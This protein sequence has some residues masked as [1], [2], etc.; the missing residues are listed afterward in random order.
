MKRC[1]VLCLGMSYP[2]IHAQ[3]ETEG[4]RHDV[5]ETTQTSI[6][7]VVECVR[8]RILTEMDG[9]DLARCIAME[10]KHCI[11]AFTASQENGSVYV[12]GKHFSGNFNRSGFVDSIK[13]Q[14]GEDT[15]F[16]QIILDYFWC[17]KGWVKEHWTKRFFHKVIP[18]L[19]QVL[20]FP[21]QPEGKMGHGV[22]YLPFCFHIMKELV[23]NLGILQD[24]YQIG[25]VYKS[26]LAEN[27]LWSGTNS[28][29]PEIMQDYLGK[30]IQQEE[31]YCTFGPQD[32]YEEMEDARVT[33]SEVIDVLRRIEDFPLVRMIRLRPLAKHCTQKRCNPEQ[34]ATGGFV[35]LERPSKIV[36]GFDQMVGAKAGENDTLSTVAETDSLD[37]ESETEAQR[38]L[39]R[40]RL[41]KAKQLK[42]RTS[43]KKVIR[44][45][46]KHLRNAKEADGGTRKPF[47][48]LIGRRSVHLQPVGL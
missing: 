40:I 26:E 33:K 46:K 34:P 21:K 20:D 27:A 35:G 1:K 24:Y 30:N 4:F 16:R 45:V 5:L 37:D 11:E 48:I 31:I 28:I 36:N 17:P 41:R 44:R 3:I 38:V 32:V 29:S 8:R 18:D 19:V 2:D 39:K 42:F 12:E 7:Q 25:F 14:F 13:R 43:K 22:L 47:F 15:K 10:K 6:L 23:A 9:R